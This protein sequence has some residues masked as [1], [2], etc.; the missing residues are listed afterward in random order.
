MDDNS[1]QQQLL[2]SP[3]SQQD[4][5]LLPY[6]PPS[7]QKQ[8]QSSPLPSSPRKQEQSP[9]LQE[10]MLSLPTLSPPNQLPSPLQSPLKQKQSPSQS[11]NCHDGYC[12]KQM[13]IVAAINDLEKNKE[14]EQPLTK[15]SKTPYVLFDM[16]TAATAATQKQLDIDQIEFGKPVTV[17][18]A[19]VDVNCGS[20]RHENQVEVS[21]Q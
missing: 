13:M 19:I 11:K 21:T 9:L 8:E 14:C 7:P 3:I 5:T 4:Q 2:P 10:Q 17:Q 1:S 15:D 16:V 18:P 20:P 6:L 12:G